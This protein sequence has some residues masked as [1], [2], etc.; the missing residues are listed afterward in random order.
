VDL[1]EF[2]ENIN[3]SVKLILVLS[4]LYRSERKDGADLT[5]SWIVAGVNGASNFPPKKRLEFLAK[6]G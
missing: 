3:P 6:Q 5:L 1:V 4:Q 2:N